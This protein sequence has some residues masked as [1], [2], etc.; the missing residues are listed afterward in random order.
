MRSD[1]RR[2]GAAQLARDACKFSSGPDSLDRFNNLPAVKIFG[3][4]APGISSGQAIARVEQI[5]KEVLPPD[6]SYD[7]GGTSYQEKRVERRVDV[8]ARRSR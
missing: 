8:R 5:A 6:F 2:H 4:A 1:T 7:W 3:S